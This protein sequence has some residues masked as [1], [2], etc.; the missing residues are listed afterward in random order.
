MERADAWLRAGGWGV[1]DVHARKPYDLVGRRAGQEL[2]V[3][4]RAR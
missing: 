3:E 4:V 1:E 2:R